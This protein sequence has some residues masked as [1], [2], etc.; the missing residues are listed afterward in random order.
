MA[1]DDDAPPQRRRKL[2]LV[3]GGV[4]VVAVATAGTVY[5]LRVDDKAA[6]SAQTTLPTDH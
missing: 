4:A 6:T 5:A 2:W 3:V 1:T